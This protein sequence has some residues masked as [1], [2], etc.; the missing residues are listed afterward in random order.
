MLKLKH[1]GP[2]EGLSDKARV[3]KLPFANVSNKITGLLEKVRPCHIPLALVTKPMS[4][5]FVTS[6][7]GDILSS[8][9]SCSA[10]PADAGSNTIV[11]ESLAQF[12]EMIQERGLNYLCP[13]GRHGIV[14]HIIWI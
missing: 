7:P 12:G 6:M 10:D 1:S 13:C 2:V 11:C 4:K 9:E 3:T 14:S 5:E 8:E